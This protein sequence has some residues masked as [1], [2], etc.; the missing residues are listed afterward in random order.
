MYVP[1]MQ[2]SALAGGGAYQKLL[3]ALA[4]G[5]RVKSPVYFRR[6][7]HDFKT[8]SDGYTFI[9]QRGK[10]TDA[11]VVPADDRVRQLIEFQRLSVVAT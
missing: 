1:R 11:I 9:L 10:D 6:Q 8:A 5:W 7:W 2:M 4:D 3:G